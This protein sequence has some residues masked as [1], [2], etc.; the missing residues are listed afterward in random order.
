MRLLA[1][2]QPTT[3]KPAKHREEPPVPVPALAIKGDGERDAGKTAGKKETQSKPAPAAPAVPVVDYSRPTNSTELL[4]DLQRRVI[5]VEEYQSRKLT[6]MEYAIAVE[7]ITHRSL[8]QWQRDGTVIEACKCTN[9]RCKG[10]RMTPVEHHRTAS[11]E[12]VADK[13]T[14][15]VALSELKDQT[16]ALKTEVAALIKPSP[17][18]TV[19]VKAELKKESHESIFKKMIKQGK[20]EQKGDTTL[21]PKDGPINWS[22]EEHLAFAHAFEMEELLELEGKP[23]ELQRRLITA[24]REIGYDILTAPEKKK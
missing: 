18:Q 15:A 3:E 7:A 16:T 12:T 13:R 6:A 10:W 19:K 23:R 1:R 14:V 21:I 22:H 20:V 24:L 2:Q 8:D 9:V 11:K 17:E 4:L 5:A